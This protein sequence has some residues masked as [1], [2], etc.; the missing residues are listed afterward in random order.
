MQKIKV[1][2]NKSFIEINVK[3]TNFFSKFSGLMFKSNKTSNLLFEF[4]EDVKLSIHS[5]FVFFP[6]LAIWLDGRN[7]IIEIKK[8]S[9]FSLSIRPERAFRK[10]IELPF[11]D[12]TMKLMKKLSFSVGEKRFK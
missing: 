11:N 9:P 5:C 4:D 12:E 7:K 6:F 10:L 1:L 8:I 2:H 3:K